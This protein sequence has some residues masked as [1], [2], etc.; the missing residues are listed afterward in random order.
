VIAVEPVKDVQDEC[1][2]AAAK[3]PNLVPHW[4]HKRLGDIVHLLKKRN[5]KI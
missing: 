1:D 5:W 3:E 2:E 4:V